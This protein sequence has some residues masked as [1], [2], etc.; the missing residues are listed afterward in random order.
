MSNLI[1]TISARVMRDLANGLQQQMFFWGQD[2]IHPAGNA[3]RDYGF[4]RSPTTGLKGTSCYKLDWAGGHLELYGSCVGWYG[5]GKGFT[6]I[7]PEKRCVVWNSSEESPIP[8][9]WQQELISKDSSREDL[10]KA[11]LPFLDWLISYEESILKTHGEAYREEAYQRYQ[12]V[13]KAKAWIEPKVALQWFK[14]L[15]NTPDQ[16]VT[17]KRFMAQQMYVN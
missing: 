16:I 2:V 1:V 13:P 5:N 7:R 10:Y 9:A 15:R 8:G 11:S 14:C 17:P 6:F 3:L 12:K 4:Q